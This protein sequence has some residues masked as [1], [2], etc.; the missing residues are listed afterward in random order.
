M[1]QEF[2]TWLWWM[3]EEDKTFSLPDGRM[4]NLAMGERISLAP[5]FGHE[6]NRVASAGSDRNLAEAREALRQ[7]KLVDSLR[8]AFILDSEEYWLTLESLWLTPKSIKLPTTAGQ[9]E[10]GADADANAL[11]RIALMEN[12]TLSLNHLFT[13]FLE[14]RL[15]HTSNWPALQ[16]WKTSFHS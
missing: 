2:L 8:M 7:G 16:N 3:S 4:L 11:E 12:L 10:A 9:D 6:G 13:L 15:K 14:E 5:P 1:G